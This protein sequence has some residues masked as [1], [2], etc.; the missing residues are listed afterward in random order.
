MPGHQQM[1]RTI[2]EFSGIRPVRITSL[3]P[4]RTA[5]EPQ[6]QQWLALAQRLGQSD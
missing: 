3:G 1:R 4:V 5:N 2:L 6:R